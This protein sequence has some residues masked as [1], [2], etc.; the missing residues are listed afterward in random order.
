MKISCTHCKHC[1]LPLSG[2]HPTITDVLCEVNMY[3]TMQLYKNTDLDDLVKRGAWRSCETKPKY[4]V[5]H[6]IK[7]LL[8]GL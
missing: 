6:N 1:R 7:L 3:Q 5:H 2:N 8:Q 4:G